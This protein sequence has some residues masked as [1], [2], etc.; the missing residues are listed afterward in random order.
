MKELLEIMARLRDPE[1]GCPWDRKQTFATIAPYTIE[2][3][4]E[5]ADAIERGDMPELRDELGDLLF[6][7]VFYAQM[8]KEQGEFEFDDVVQAICN[9]MRRRHPHVFGEA[10][11]GSAEEQH[12]AWEESKR[13][14]RA[15]KAGDDEPS[16]LDG[17]AGALPALIR[18]EKLQKRAARAGFDWP[19]PSG[20]FAKVHEELDEVAE[21][22]EQGVGH[23]RLAEEIG[24]LL[25]ACVNLARHAGVDAETALAVGNRKFERRFRAMEQG[26]AKEGKRLEE[27]DM[28]EMEAQWQQVKSGEA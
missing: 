4:Y 23:E 15:A 26:L 11:I 22:L 17:V 18:A 1:E 21:E 28:D 16:L 10:E 12:Q 8:A 7:V 20:V 5:V 19:D 25:F 9:K 24:D 27:M 6:Q 2:E 3:A 14:E 13:E